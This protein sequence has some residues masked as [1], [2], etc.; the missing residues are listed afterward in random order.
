VALAWALRRGLHG[1]D[2]GLDRSAAGRSARVGGLLAAGIV[3]VV[4]LLAAIGAL[5]ADPEVAGLDGG[6]V[7]FRLLVAIPIGTAIGEELLFRGVLLAAWD[8]VLPPGRSAAVVSALFG[9]WHVVAE[10]QRTGGVALVGGVVATAAV[11]L[12]VLCPLRRRTG[13]VVAPIVVHAA[14]NTSVLAAIWWLAR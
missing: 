1:D 11:S 2:L 7:A 5:P 8:R 13:S 4:A 6:R 9:L 14:T 10:W 12:F 3:A